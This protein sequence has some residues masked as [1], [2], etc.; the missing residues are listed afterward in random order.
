MKIIK[1]GSNKVEKISD[2][3]TGYTLYKDLDCE[4]DEWY[5][6]LCKDG[7][8]ILYLEIGYE[9]DYDINSYVSNIN[10]D[11]SVVGDVTVITE[12]GEVCGS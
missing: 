6:T 7:K 8:P 2:T 12:K 11:I 5:F 9:M 3:Y 1:I 4:K 10:A